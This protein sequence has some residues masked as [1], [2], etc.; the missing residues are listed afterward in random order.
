MIFPVGINEN[1]KIDRIESYPNPTTDVLNL[2]FELTNKNLVSVNL[3]DITGKV[4]TNKSFGNLSSG[5]Y[6]ESFN[7]SSFTSGIYFIEVTVGNER[8]VNRFIVK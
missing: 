1:I 3:L 6:N 5:T 2:R 4:L 7:T 8:I